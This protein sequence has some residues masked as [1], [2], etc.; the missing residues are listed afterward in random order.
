MSRY[1][2]ITNLASRQS[3]VM[4]CRRPCDD[5]EPPRIRPGRLTEAGTAR[6]RARPQ[7]EGECLIADCKVKPKKHRYL[8]AKHYRHFWIGKGKHK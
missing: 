5:M 6:G 4:P 7:I 2:K 1:R 8:C 3:G